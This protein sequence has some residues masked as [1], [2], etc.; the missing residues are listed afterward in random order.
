MVDHGFVKQ[1]SVNRSLA[2][3]LEFDNDELCTA[4][5]DW[6]CASQA[7]QH[8]SKHMVLPFVRQELGLG[9]QGFVATVHWFLTPMLAVV[10]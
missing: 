10:K 5:H 4:M 7:V 8:S 3:R 6:L 1:S 9:L 2:K